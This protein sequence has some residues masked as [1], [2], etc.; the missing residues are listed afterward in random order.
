MG[1]TPSG[2]SVTGIVDEPPRVEGQAHVIEPERGNVGDVRLRDKA[3]AEA[4]PELGC[5]LGSHQ[6]LDAGLDLPR[7]TTCRCQNFHM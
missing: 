4:P 1:A 7:A 5:T 2:I 3:V 6:R